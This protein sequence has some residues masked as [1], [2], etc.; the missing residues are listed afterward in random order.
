M[1]EK[2]QKKKNRTHTHMHGH[3]LHTNQPPSQPMSQPDIFSDSAIDTYL[4][5]GL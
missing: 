5:N 3:P 1:N 2:F 4:L